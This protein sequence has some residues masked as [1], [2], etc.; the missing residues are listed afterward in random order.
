[1]MSMSGSLDD[2]A[3]RVHAPLPFQA[4]EPERRVVDRLRIRILLEHRPEFGGLL[5]SR[6]RRIGD[7][8]KRD[9]LLP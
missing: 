6:V 5:V 8:R 3:G 9:V 7:A 1:M 4:L 2:H